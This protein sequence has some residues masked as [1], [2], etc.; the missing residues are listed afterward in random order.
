MFGRSAVLPNLETWLLSQLV[1]VT[2]SL[3]AKVVTVTF[4]VCALMKTCSRDAC[5]GKLSA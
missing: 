5:G 4:T 2:L 1:S 3:V